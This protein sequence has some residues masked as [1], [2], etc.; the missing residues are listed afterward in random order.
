MKTKHSSGNLSYASVALLA[1]VLTP[2]IGAAQ[3]LSDVQS[4]GN[5]HLKESGSFYIQGN[6]ISETAIESGLNIAGIRMINQMYV[7]FQKPQ[8][9]NGKNHVPIVFVH[10]GG[11]S[12]KSWQTTPDGRMGW[13]EYFVRQGFDTYLAD[14]VA[15]ARSGFDGRTFNNVRAGLVPPAQQP[16]ISLPTSQY[17][18][19]FVL[20]RLLAQFPRAMP[21]PRLAPAFDSRSVLLV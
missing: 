11:L 3:V 10:G 6:M 8:A 19:R 2:S 4:N 9:Q 16:V 14:Q 12:S 13:Y 7:E 17:G 1:F 15:R 18:T 20:Q 21:R 5:L